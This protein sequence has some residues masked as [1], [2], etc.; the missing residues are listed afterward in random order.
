[1]NEHEQEKALATIEVEKKL[2][3]SLMLDEGLAIPNVST[4]LTAEDFYRPEH[5]LIYRA[6]QSLYGKGTPLNVLLVENELLRTDELKR[7]ISP[8]SANMTAP[9]TGPMPGILVRRVSKGVN[10]AAILSSSS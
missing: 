1:M 7:V 4:I 6:L 8:I 2:L 10:K 3:S 5:R 9:R